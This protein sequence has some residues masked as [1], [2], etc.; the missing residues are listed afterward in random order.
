MGRKGQGIIYSE[1]SP[2]STLF[3]FPLQP[4]S[5]SL[6]PHKRY[7]CVALRRRLQLCFIKGSVEL[8]N[9]TLVPAS[10]YVRICAVIILTI[11]IGCE[12]CYW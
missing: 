1:A 10:M 5:S 4:I 9:R 3:P 12:H 6:L 7:I 2:H 8:V 11:S